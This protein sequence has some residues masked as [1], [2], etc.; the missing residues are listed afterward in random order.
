MVTDR[1]IKERARCRETEK[2]VQ[3]GWRKGA[4]E[5]EER[6]SRGEREIDTQR[7][8]ETKKHDVRQRKGVRENREILMLE[9]AAPR[10]KGKGED[11]MW[12]V[13]ALMNG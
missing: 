2:Y 3:E 10:D 4:E 9:R 6:K 8:R 7:E 5:R 12:N 1:K 11:W 13:H